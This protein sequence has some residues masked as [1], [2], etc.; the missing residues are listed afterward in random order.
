MASYAELFDIGEDFTAFVGHGLATEQGAVAR[1]RQ[2][3]ESNGLPSAL[4]ERLQ[5]IERRYR[6]L[7]AGEMWCP[8]CQINLA[9]LDFAQR[10]QPNIE[11]AIISKGRA[12]D[13]LRQRLALERIAIP[14]VLVL[15][16]EFNLLGRFVERPQAVLDGGP[17]ALAAYKAGDY[18]EH[19]IGDVLA[20]IEGAAR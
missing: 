7:V 10:L 1:F 14:L 11:L 17:Q 5:R 12:E 4:T 16:E 20:I 9:A 6:L 13:D 8:D 19:A 18:L 15:D 3:L 2:K